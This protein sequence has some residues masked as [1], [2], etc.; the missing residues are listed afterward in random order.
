MIKNAVVMCAGSGLGLWPLTETAPK[1]LIRILG[2]SILQRIVEGLKDAGMEK[3]C[4]VTYYLEKKITKE[5]TAI[6]KKA[7]VKPYFIRQKGALGTADAVKSA[8][9]RVKGPFLVASGDHVLDVSI[10]RDA[11]NAFDGKDLV[12]LKRVKNPS[13]YGVAEV[14]NGIITGR[15]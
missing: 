14:E 6:C 11:V 8:K 7:R 4:F 3:I 2:K 9:R 5:A 13:N 1:P 12:V 15:S 10:Y